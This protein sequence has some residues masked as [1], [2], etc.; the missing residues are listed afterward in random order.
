MDFKARELR[1]GLAERGRFDA[2]A[3]KKA[4]QAQRFGNVELLSAPAGPSE[5]RSP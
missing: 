2:E 4:L 5:E 1:F 3:V